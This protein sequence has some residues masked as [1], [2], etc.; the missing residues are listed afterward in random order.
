MNLR[1]LAPDAAVL[2][3]ALVWGCSF[4]AVQA[5]AAGASV[6]L[7]LGLRFA[8]AV[9]LLLPVAL[10][11]ARRRPAAGTWRGALRRGWPAGLLLL[12][13]FTLET[14]GAVR[15]SPA[16]AGVLIAVFAVVVPFAAALRERRAPRW[17]AA[18]AGA[19]AVG[20]VALLLGPGGG[21]RTG[22]L[23]V[24]AA[25]VVRGVV[26]AMDGDREDPDPLRSTVVRLGVVSAG[27]FA[28]ALLVPGAADGGLPSGVGAWGALLFLAGPCTAFALLAQRLASRR[29]SPER[30]AVLLVTE[31]VWA[32]AAGVA[33]G[34]RLGAVQVL[35]VVLV[36]GAQAALRVP[37][38]RLRAAGATRGRGATRAPVAETTGALAEHSVS[39]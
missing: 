3:V 6:A 19:V 17:G 37:W 38:G 9:L 22:D 10:L 32:A 12:V 24:L 14:H 27:S 4:V 15:T 13:I 8:L 7:V 28:A 31:P 2:S 36:L 18:A 34:E 35:G 29:T 23:L 11:L 5:A 26:T 33:V 21:V 25:A 1:T 20:G 30:V 16:R 39:A